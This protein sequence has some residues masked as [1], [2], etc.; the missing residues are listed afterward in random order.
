MNLYGDSG[1]LKVLKQ[2]LEEQGLEVSITFLSLDDT[3]DFSKYDLF[4]IGPGT[5]NNA[6]IV[7]NDILKYKEAIKKAVGSQ[8]FFLITGNALS[9]FGKRI[10]A[11]GVNLEGLNLF[12]FKAKRGSTRQVCEIVAKSKLLS[13]YLLGFKN[14]DLLIETK[15]PGIFEIEKGYGFNTNNQTDGIQKNNFLGTTIIGPILVRNPELLELISK[16]ILKKYNL[17]FKAKKTNLLEEAHQEYLKNY[18]MN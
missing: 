2:T 14:S 5:F 3:I 9:L 6:R 12:D 13:D 4:Y 16:K 8:K 18:F 11:N 1:N 15:D 17:S 10:E 7:L